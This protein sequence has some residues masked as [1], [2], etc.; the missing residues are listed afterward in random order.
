MYQRRALGTFTWHISTTF[1]QWNRAYLNAL[2][3]I[4]SQLYIHTFIQV[5]NW[6]RATCQI[7]WRFSEMDAKQEKHQ[8]A[9]HGGGLWW[10]DI[11][12]QASAKQW[13]QVKAICVAAA[14]SSSS[15]LSQRRNEEPFPPP[16]LHMSRSWMCSS[17]RWRSISYYPELE[18]NKTFSFYTSV[19]I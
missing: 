8:E 16:I 15:S 17:Q 14:A 3:N 1:V 6:A 18:N 12:I 5:N 2:C 11:S 13:L 19:D 10:E 7:V 9:G 4:S